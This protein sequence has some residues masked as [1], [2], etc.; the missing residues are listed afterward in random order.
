MEAAIDVFFHEG[1]VS[2][3]APTVSPT[4]TRELEQAFCRYRDP[5]QEC[6]ILADGVSQLCSDLQVT[7]T[8]FTLC[9]DIPPAPAGCCS[10]Y[11]SLLPLVRLIFA[12]PK[13]V[14]T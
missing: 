13:H 3:S 10:Q 2:V 1:G 9:R 12:R 6:M 7:L 11:R 4:Q 5:E 14:L 8:S